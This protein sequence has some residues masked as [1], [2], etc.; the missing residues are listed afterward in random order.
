MKIKQKIGEWLYKFPK[1]RRYLNR[2]DDINVCLNKIRNN[3]K[4]VCLAFTSTYAN[5]GDQAIVLSEKALLEKNKVNY[6]EITDVELNLLRI[7][8]VLSVLN[9]RTILFTGGG[10]LGTIWFDDAEQLYRNTVRHTPKSNIVFLPNTMYYEETEFGKQE[11]KNSID[12]YNAHNNLTFYA[13]ENVTYEFAKPLF[14]NVRFCPDMVLCLKKDGVKCERKGGLFCLRH[15]KEITRTDSEQ[16]R[17][18][19][20]MRALFLDDYFFTDTVLDI[21]R[22]K[23]DDRERVFEEK[24]N[25]FRRAKLVVTDRLHGMIFCAITATPCVVI[26]SLSHKIQGTYEWIKHLEYI[27]LVDNVDDV[28]KAYKEMPDK[29]FTY[30]NSNIVHYYDELMDYIKNLGKKNAKN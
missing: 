22:V 24:L 14:N 7:N 8:G 1:F 10:N 27:R 11:L 25:Q 6:V 5:L 30:D 28:I 15:D 9:G 4:A 19:E 17:L 2:N 23:V 29:E 12:I 21:E 3:P 18:E 16:E 13:R 20:Q 26:K